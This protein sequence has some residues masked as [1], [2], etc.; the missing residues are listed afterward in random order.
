M[1]LPGSK[2][3]DLNRPWVSK[4]RVADGKMAADLPIYVDGTRFTAPSEEES[5]QATRQVVSTVNSLGIWEAASKKRWGSKRPGAWAGSIVETTEAGVYVTVSQEKWDKC[6]RFIGKIMGELQQSG[7]DTLEFKP[8]ERKRGFLIYVTRTF[9]SMVPYLKGIHQTLDT[10]RPNWR[11]DG[12]KL[13]LKEILSRIS[14]EGSMPK[15]W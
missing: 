13:I 11:E 6:R 9:P 7:D 3:Y 15:S 5:W 4:S 8:L 2:D 10:W 14:S 12:G 1:N